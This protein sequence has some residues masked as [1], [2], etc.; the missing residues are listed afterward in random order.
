MIVDYQISQ[1]RSSTRQIYQSPLRRLK[2]QQ[3]VDPILL[4]HW[5]ATTGIP[6]VCFQMPV[7]SRQRSQIVDL[8]VLL[9]SDSFDIVTITETL[10]DSSVLDHE[11]QLYDFKI[12][13]KDR[14]GRRG[15]GVLLAVNS[16]LH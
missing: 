12:Y 16:E 13:Q 14:S 3:A 11:L 2:D 8:E 6:N 10:S 1:R 5:K 4:L 15:G 7:R 9:S